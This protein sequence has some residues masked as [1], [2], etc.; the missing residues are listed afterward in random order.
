MGYKDPE[1]RRAAGKKF[2]AEH[3][4]TVK[5]QVKAYALKNRAE[6]KAR[7]IEWRRT[8][9]AEYIIRTKRNECK[10]F[11]VEFSVTEKDLLPLPVWCPV[12]GIKLNYLVT[13]GRPEDNSPSLDR[14]NNTQG[15]VSGNVKVISNRANRL[16]SDGTIGEHLTIVEYMRRACQS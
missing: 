15:Y 5:A 3:K 7:K 9:P 2:Y 16:K 13:S 10:K 12:L 1:K 8:H 4:D 14:V 11:N 6:I